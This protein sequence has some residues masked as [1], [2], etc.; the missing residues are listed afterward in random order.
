MLATL[1]AV[2]VEAGRVVLEMA[3]DPRFTPD[4]PAT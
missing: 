3:S 1:G 2:M 4:V